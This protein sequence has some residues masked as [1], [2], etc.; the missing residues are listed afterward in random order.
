M[1]NTMMIIIGAAVVVA[2]IVAI[3]SIAMSRKRTDKHLQETFGTEYDETYAR[4]V[5][6]KSAKQELKAREE[7]VSGYE[8]KPISSEQRM[9]FL[10]EWQSMQASFVDHPGTAVN[11]ADLLLAE[12]MRARGYESSMLDQNERIADVSVGHGDEAASYREAVR[13]ATLNREGKATTEDLRRAIKD[14]AVVF[15]SLLNERQPVA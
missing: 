5:D 10:S 11:R 7:R 13:V 3:A 4:A 8:L 2:V 1:D 9:T 14:Y 6:R 12:V 15:E